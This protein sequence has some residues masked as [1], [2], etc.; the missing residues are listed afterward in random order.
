MLRHTQTAGRSTASGGSQSL[1][2]SGPDVA[3]ED[4]IY[5]VYGNKKVCSFEQ[6]VKTCLWWLSVDGSVKVNAFL[7]NK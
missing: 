4:V 3:A 5:L 2:R 1:I 7:M 6:R